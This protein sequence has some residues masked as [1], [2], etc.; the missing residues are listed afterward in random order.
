MIHMKCHTLLSQKVIIMI[1]KQKMMFPLYFEQ[2]NHFYLLGVFYYIIPIDSI[3]TEKYKR[4]IALWVNFQQITLKYFLIFPM[5]TICKKCQI[6]FSGKNKK[7][8][9]NLLSAE[10][11]LRVVKVQ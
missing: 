7:N 2:M 8:I 11:A 10:L 4:F 6:L 5:E 1:N 3:H 9:V